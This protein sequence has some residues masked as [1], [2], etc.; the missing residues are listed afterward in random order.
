MKQVGG[1]FGI[2]IVDRGLEGSVT[3]ILG[4]T[5]DL[6]MQLGQML[7]FQAQHALHLHSLA[8]VCA[9]MEIPPE[10]YETMVAGMDNYYN[11][12]MSEQGDTEPVDGDD[13][14]N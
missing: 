14:S 3:P 10:T 1:T 11:I 7:V 13:S 8:L 12:L 5:P 4:V 9:D 2:E 6:A